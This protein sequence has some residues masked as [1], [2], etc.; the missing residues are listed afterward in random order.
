[1][2]RGLQLTEQTTSRKRMN[3]TK[4]STPNLRRQVSWTLPA[5]LIYG[6]CNLL[7]IVTL[8]RLGSK[9]VA[10]KFGL[11]MAISAPIFMFANLRFSTILATDVRSNTKLSD[12]FSVR[13]V[14][15]VICWGLTIPFVIGNPTLA[16]LVLVI[17]TSKAIESIS[18][19]CCG[20][21]Q[22]IHRMDRIAISL[23]SNGLLM[24]AAFFVVYYV[25]RSLELAAV[26]ICV[27]RFSVLLLYD[28]PKAR[29]AAHNDVFQTGDGYRQKAEYDEPERRFVFSSREWALLRM[30]APLGITAA[31]ISLTSN[32]PRYVIP[33]I[34]SEEMLGV[35]ISLAVVLQAGNLVFRAVELPTIPKLATYINRREAGNFWRLMARAVGLFLVLGIVGSFAAWGFGGRILASV[36]GPTYLGCGLLL[37]LM[38]FGTSFSQIAGMIESSLIASRWT[39]VQIPMHCVTVLSCLLLCFSLIPH[40]R[41][42]GAVI[43]VTLCRVPFALV[44]L[45]MLQR[46]LNSPLEKSEYSDEEVDRPDLQSIPKA[47]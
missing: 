5:N 23:I 43:A 35:F 30:G 17:A 37:A 46:K 19:L 9:V 47:A 10:G 16:I 25:S 20:V 3:A 14:L 44:G 15:L 34:L 12:Y 45:W 31:L 24:A 42:Y 36:Y 18:E 39:T 41:L 22:R 13:C 28:I 11:A 26:A 33:S 1:M 7:L 40:Y 32:I 21:Q 8:N 2:L 27:T 38:T 6:V 29:E 4:S